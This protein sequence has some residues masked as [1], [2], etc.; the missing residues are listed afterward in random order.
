MSNVLFYSLFAIFVMFAF[1]R[2]FKAGYRHGLQEGF[3]VCYR[4]FH[5][6]EN[7]NN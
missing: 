3:D 6:S 4:G 1:W 7:A 2:G 5:E